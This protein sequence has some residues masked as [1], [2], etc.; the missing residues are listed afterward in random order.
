MDKR[1]TKNQAYKTKKIANINYLI[2]I[3][4]E[5]INILDFQS[6][7]TTLQIWNNFA[8]VSI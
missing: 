4:N 6:I 3:N 8:N 5:A 1:R 7:W 2:S